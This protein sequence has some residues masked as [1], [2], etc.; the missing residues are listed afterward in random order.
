MA[1]INTRVALLEQG[2]TTVATRL[3]RHLQECADRHRE[4]ARIAEEKRAEDIKFYK[5]IIASV[6]VAA[7]MGAI[8]LA[9]IGFKV[10]AKTP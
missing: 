5:G 7:I 9:V 10:W 3:D 8:G 2:H 1:D 6:V 4:A